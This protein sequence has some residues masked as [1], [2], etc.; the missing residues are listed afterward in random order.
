MP[1]FKEKIE[2]AHPMISSSKAPAAGH[3]PGGPELRTL[4]SARSESSPF[5]FFSP[6]VL[7]IPPLLQVI[8]KTSKYLEHTLHKSSHLNDSIYR[9]SYLKLRTMHKLFINLGVKRQRNKEISMSLWN[10]L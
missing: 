4:T 1:R 9:K 2:G 6:S 3:R 8:I 5:N 10:F 7:M